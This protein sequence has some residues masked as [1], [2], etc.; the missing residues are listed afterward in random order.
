MNK[1][2]TIAREYGSGGREVGK[3][4][5]DLLK[6]DFYDRELITLA[7]EQSGFNVDALNHVDE[8]ASSSLLYTLAMGSSMIHNAV[9]VYNMPLNDQLFIMQSHLI[10]ELAEKAPCVFVGRCADYILENRPAVMKVFLYSSFEARVKSIA[11]QRGISEAEAKS[12]IVRTDRRRANYYNY[13]SG[14]KWGK[15]ENYDIAISTDVL[16]I[17]GTAKLL[18]DMYSAWNPKEEK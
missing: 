15:T 12:D 11:Q 4:L 10:E 5:A 8:K 6:I 3:L 1:V 9:D 17:E 7:A 16:G 14:K 13:Y 18:A 2:I